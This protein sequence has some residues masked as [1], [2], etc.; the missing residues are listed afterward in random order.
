MWVCLNVIA[1]RHHASG[2][3]SGTW[4]TCE[5][6]QV[7]SVLPLISVQLGHLRSNSVHLD[8]LLS[9][10]MLHRPLIYRW[11]FAYSSSVSQPPLY[12]SS[13]LLIPYESVLLRGKSLILLGSCHWPWYDGSGN[14][15][16]VGTSI[17][18]LHLFTNHSWQGIHIR[19]RQGAV[20]RSDETAGGRR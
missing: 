6:L 2:P 3:G 18:Y 20:G 19:S 16:I 17:E 9:L 12:L 8:L 4:R 1:L 5:A 15:S 14:K 7:P 13:H 10:S 11:L